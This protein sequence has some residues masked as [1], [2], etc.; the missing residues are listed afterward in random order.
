MNKALRQRVFAKYDGHC[1]YCGCALE[2]DNMQVDHLKAIG[3]GV[4]D[5]QL[6]EQRGTDDFDNLMPSCRMCNFYKA[7]LD[8]ESFRSKI[9]NTLDYKHTFATNMALKYGILTEH[10]W[11][12]KFY[13]ETIN[14][15]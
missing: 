1:A 12:G 11:S 2:Y 5:E 7:R 10:V 8:I 13:F 4:P 9:A 6:M 15:K 3:R 14:N